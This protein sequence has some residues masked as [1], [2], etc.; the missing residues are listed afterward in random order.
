MIAVPP[1]P[2]AVPS[3]GSQNRNF[4]LGVFFSGLVFSLAVCGGEEV[5]LHRQLAPVEQNLQEEKA[6]Q[7]GLAS[8]EGTYRKYD[9][10]LR[11]LEARINVIQGLLGTRTSPANFMEEVR[12]IVNRTGEVGVSRIIPQGKRVGLQGQVRSRDLMAKF[13][14]ALQRSGKFSD[15]QLRRLDEERQQNRATY[16]FDLDSVYSPSSAGPTGRESEGPSGPQ[17]P[18]D[19]QAT[20]GK[21]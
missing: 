17:A 12:R 7:A 2:S 3:R 1:A 15:V 6:R 21:S 5:L 16:I 4:Q 11:D 18:R 14:A 9:L 19:S 20:K 8:D 10:T 13:L